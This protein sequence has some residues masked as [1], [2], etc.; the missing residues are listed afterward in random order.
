ME[1][2]CWRIFWLNNK[3]LLFCTKV[4]MKF[5]V[6]FKFYSHQF[7]KYSFTEYIFY[8]FRNMSSDESTSSDSGDDDELNQRCSDIVQQ[9]AATTVLKS[10]GRSSGEANVRTEH[11]VNRI[12][13]KNKYDKRK[14]D[15]E[16]NVRPNIKMSTDICKTGQNYTSEHRQKKHT[17]QDTFV[18][19]EVEVDDHPSDTLESEEDDEAEHTEEDEYVRYCS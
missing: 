9:T 3:I 18:S 2:A 13:S 14:Y 5:G 19:P 6:R 16:T 10:T 11:S 4:S 7:I 17:L 15:D 8:Y 1:L 12:P